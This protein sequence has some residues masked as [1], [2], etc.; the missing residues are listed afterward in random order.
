MS[1]AREHQMG[2]AAGLAF[3]TAIEEYARTNRVSGR[4]LAAAGCG[5]AFA[6]LPDLIEPATSPNHRKFFHSV[7]FAVAVAGTMYQLYQWDAQT[8]G[9][10]L[11]RGLLLLAGGAYLIHLAMDAT[12]R[13][14]LPLI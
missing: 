2:A 6:S 5:V 4:C 7:T 1:C 8:D 9:E 11:L 3:A 10:R 12:T 13:K 14:S